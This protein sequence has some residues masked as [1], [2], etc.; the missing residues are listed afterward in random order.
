MRLDLLAKLNAERAARR[1]VV[2]VTDPA[3]GKQRLVLEADVDAASRE[4]PDRFV[5]ATG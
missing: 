3:N 1:G 4:Y 2:V 5:L